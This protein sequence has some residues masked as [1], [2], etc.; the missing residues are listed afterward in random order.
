MVVLAPLQ[1]GRR[2]VRT[3]VVAPRRFTQHRF[4]RV[5]GAVALVEPDEHVG[6]ERPL[7]RVGLDG[8]A[9][10]RQPRERALVEI[11]CIGRPAILP[12][13]FAELKERLGLVASQGFIRR[14]EPACLVVAT[15]VEG[16]RAHPASGLAIAR[17][18]RRHKTVGLGREPRQVLGERD[19]TSVPERVGARLGP[20]DHLRDGAREQTRGHRLRAARRASRPRVRAPRRKAI[21]ER[22]PRFVTR[23]RHS[24]RAPSTPP[25][26][27]RARSAGATSATRRDARRASRPRGRGV[28]AGRDPPGPRS[29]QAARRPRLRPRARRSPT[30]VTRQRGEAPRVTLPL[31]QPGSTDRSALRSAPR[32]RDV[33]RTPTIQPSPSS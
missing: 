6:Q 28:A 7:R 23:R 27:R 2:E 19:T 16:Q 22:P 10:V 15:F 32:V 26:R 31:H 9:R 30:A 33:R 24:P 3:H 8:G 18:A 1:E 25:D 14:E 20:C 5:H 11:A 13:Q 17:L 12:G 21:P 4:E 29:R